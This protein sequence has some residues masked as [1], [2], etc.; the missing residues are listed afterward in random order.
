MYSNQWFPTQILS[1][2]EEVKKYQSLS[3]PSYA[4]I[5]LGATWAAGF[6]F[7]CGKHNKIYHF[8]V[9]IEYIHNLARPSPHLIPEYSHH[10][11]KKSHLH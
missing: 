6:F 10:S 2:D 9:Y 7:N 11:K 4:V 8:E 3:P 5:S 1:V